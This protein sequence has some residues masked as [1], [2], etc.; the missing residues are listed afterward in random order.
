MD[1]R[2]RHA[3]VSLDVGFGGRPPMHAGI[4]VDEGQILALLGREAGSVAVALSM[5]AGQRRTCN[6]GSV[7]WH[8]VNGF[9]D[10]S[11]HKAYKSPIASALIWAHP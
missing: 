3:E 9:T 2:R 4:S 6:C 7:A 10:S 8:T 5:I 11:L 1:G